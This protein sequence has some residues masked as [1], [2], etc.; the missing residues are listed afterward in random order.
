MPINLRASK[1]PTNAHHP[2]AIALGRHGQ[3]MIVH[4]SAGM[5]SATLLLAQKSIRRCYGWPAS[6]MCL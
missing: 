3:G 6:G 1:C 4:E 2:R 5:L